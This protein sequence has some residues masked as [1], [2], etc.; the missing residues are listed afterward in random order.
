MDFAEI[1]EK[2]DGFL[3]PEA[4]SKQARKREL[5]LNAATELF[6]AY[7]YRKT[8]IDDVAGATSNGVV[9]AYIPRHSVS[10]GSSTCGSSAQPRGPTACLSASST[11]GSIS[12]MT[13]FVTPV[14][15]SGAACSH[16]KTC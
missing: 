6:I 11:D 16:S 1:A 12:V 13:I 8:T 15:C 10:R 4:D 14:S 2:I 3:N 9:P 5:I 7:G